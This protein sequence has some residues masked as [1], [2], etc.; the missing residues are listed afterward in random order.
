MM[1]DFLPFAW[2][3]KSDDVDDDDISMKPLTNADDVE[4]RNPQIM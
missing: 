3:L 1:F 2:R 4:E